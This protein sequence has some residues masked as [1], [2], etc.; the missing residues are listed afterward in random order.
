MYRYAM[1]NGHDAHLGVIKFMPHESFVD[2]DHGLTRED[3]RERDKKRIL[4]ALRGDESCESPPNRL[5]DGHRVSQAICR[6]GLFIIEASAP[7][8]TVMLRFCPKRQNA[9]DYEI[10][11]R[12]HGGVQRR[13]DYQVKTVPQN[14]QDEPASMLTQF[15]IRYVVF[16]TASDRP[17]RQLAW[18]VGLNSFRNADEV[19]DADSPAG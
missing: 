11:Y 4:D 6:D 9:G 1:L 12:P 5:V 3:R 17:G 18:L 10:H 8:F 7:A 2:P 14:E 15:P 19:V 16:T 13:R